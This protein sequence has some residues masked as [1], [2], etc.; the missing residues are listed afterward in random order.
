MSDDTENNVISLRDGKPDTRTYE[1]TLINNQRRYSA[2]ACQH[3]GPFV[4]DRKLATVECQDCGALLSPMYV[5]E[6]L[7]AHETY[8]NMR[9]RELTTYLAE[10]NKELEGRQR[11]KCTHCGNMTAIK[12]N[13]EPPKTWFPMPY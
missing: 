8:W 5:L 1:T 9:Q 2:Q 6:M 10:V 4:V 12:F 11:T 3:K 13:K 7:A